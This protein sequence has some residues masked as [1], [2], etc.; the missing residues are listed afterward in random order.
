MYRGW[1]LLTRGSGRN[2]ETSDSRS[3]KNLKIKDYLVVQLDISGKLIKGK[4]NHGRKDK[5]KEFISRKLLTR[6]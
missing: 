4:R 2:M 1:M 5:C 3:N 6:I